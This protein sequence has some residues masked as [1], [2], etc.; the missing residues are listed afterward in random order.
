[1][2]RTYSLV[3]LL[4]SFSMI[5]S[6]LNFAPRQASA[7]NEVTDT[8]TVED[9]GATSNSYVNWTK[10]KS[11]GAEY[12][13]NSSKNGSGNNASIQLKSKDSTSGIVTTT[14]GRYAEKFEINWGSNNT[15][16]KAVLIYGRNEPYTGVSDLYGS[17]KGN[18]IGSFT[19][20]ESGADTVINADESKQYRYIG[21]RSENGAVYIKS[22][23]ITW[24]SKAP[25][26]TWADDFSS[27]SAYFEDDDETVNATITS[28]VTKEATYTADGE[29]EYTATVTY[30][31][32]TYKDIKT[33]V[34][35]ALIPPMDVTYIDADGT[36]QTHE[37]TVLTGSEGDIASGWYVAKENIT[38]S[39]LDS[40][41]SI[42]LIICDGVTVTLTGGIDARNR[43]TVYGQSDGSGTIHSTG[44]LI[45]RAKNITINGGTFIGTK[46]SNDCSLIVATD[47]SLGGNL[48]VNRGTFTDCKLR[49]NGSV[50]INGGTINA[51]R[52]D[53]ENAID[54]PHG[55]IIINGGKI[56][57]DDA[58]GTLYSVIIN[59]SDPEDSLYSKSY[60]TGSGKVTLNH[61]LIDSDGNKYPAGEYA[62]EDL[63][64][65]TLTPYIPSEWE[66][67]QDLIDN[68][69]F[70]DTITLTKDYTAGADDTALVIP[71]GK[72]I[73][74]DLGNHTLDRGL[75]DSAAEDNGNVITVYGRL[76]INGSGTVTGGKN[77][78]SG[79]AICINSGHV[80]I[81]GGV[82]TGNT[83]KEAGA[84]FN[85]EHGSLNIAGGTFTCNSAVQFGGGAIVN[86]GTMR[87]GK[88]EIKGNSALG[89]GGGIWNGGT[90]ILSGGTITGNTVMASGSNGAGI[91]NRAGS[92]I[93]AF[94]T[95]VVTGNTAFNNKANNVYIDSGNYINITGNLAS[96][97]RIA[98]TAA[99]ISMNKRVL[100]SG[101]SGSGTAD[102]FISDRDDY[103]VSLNDQGEATYTSYYFVSFYPNGG[104]GSMARIKTKESSI[105]LPDCD[106]T[107][108][109]GKAFSCWIDESNYSEHNAGDTFEL[110]NYYK[111]LHPSWETLYNITIADVENGTVTPDK[112]S[113]IKDE[114]V[115]LTVT[116]AED[117]VLDSLTVTNDSTKNEIT[118]TNGSFMMPASNVTVTA[119]FRYVR[120]TQDLPFEIHNKAD[121][122]A[123]AQKVNSGDDTA[124]YYKLAD[125]FDNSENITTTVGT[126]AHPFAGHFDGNGKTLIVKINDTDA[127]GTAPF[128]YISG[129]VI[130]DLTVEGTVQGTTHAAGLVG[131]NWSGE[132]VISNVTVDVDVTNP[133]ESGNR[134]IGGVVGH[135]KSSKITMTNVVCDSTLKNSG[136][137]AG[138][139]VGWSDDSKIVL[140][141][142]VF[143]GYYSGDGKFHPIGF[144]AEGCNVTCSVNKVFSLSGTKEGPSGIQGNYIGADAVLVYRSLTTFVS[145]KIT[146]ADGQTYYAPA[147]VEGIEEIYNA[148]GSE[149]VPGITVVNYKNETLVN[150]TDYEVSISPYPV[151]EAG[152]YTVTVTGLGIQD[153]TYTTTFEV[154]GPVP[155]VDA[156][157]ADM[158]PLTEYEVISSNSTYLSDD[159]WYVVMGDVTV[160]S[161]ITVNGD[162]NI[163][164]CDGASLHASKGITVLKD[165]SLTVWQQ[166]E[167]T[168]SILIDDVDRFCAGIGSTGVGGWGTTYCGTITV[169]GGKIT[170]AGGE[171]GAGIGGGESSHGGVI[172]INAGEVTAVG[173]MNAAGIGGGDAGNSGNITI[174]GGTVNAKGGVASAGIGAGF[175]G[176]GEFIT[177]NGG[178][179]TAKS[180]ST[181]A[182]IGG[183]EKYG[184]HNTG[185]GGTITIAGGIVTA[186]TGTTNQRGSGIGNGNGGTDSVIILSWTDETKD[187][188]SVTSD[189]YSGTVTMEMPF[190]DNDGTI[191]ASGEQNVEALAGKTVTPY[192][193]SGHLAGFTVSLEGDIGVNFHMILSQDVVNSDNAYV[194]FKVAGGASTKVFVKD[195]RDN[196]RKIGT[197]TYYVFKCNVK[198]KEMNKTVTAQLYVDNAKRGDEYTFSVRSYSKY[199]IDN[200]SASEEFAN[201]VPLV[202][203]ML[204]YGTAAQVYFDADVDDPANNVLDPEDR[205]YG[206][207]TKD[208]VSS[209]KTVIAGAAPEGVEFYGLSLILRT[210]TSLRFYFKDAVTGFT[211]KDPSGAEITDYKTGTA[212]NKFYI[213]IQD[214][215]ANDLDVTYTVTVGE[216]SITAGPLAYVYSVLDKFASDTDK[217]SLCDAVKALYT[218]YSEADDY[219]S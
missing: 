61:A 11:S 210:K 8:L 113:A 69:G 197:N 139:F 40:G 68:A 17:A 12:A 75:T 200:Q 191:Y 48:V 51:V 187:S 198:A 57:S 2:K 5:I 126:Q 193:E 98:V 158:T 102:N 53:Y 28:R 60:T 151:I 154:H 20:N 171:D 90:L 164:L 34:I 78:G 65:K 190:A 64:E 106:F 143:T 43:I 49:G 71:D 97:A 176:N 74:L 30:N 25:E 41:G 155:Y 134:H 174:N 166:T 101:L 55:D 112:V 205:T 181:G 121:W 179:V 93:N 186:S 36:P 133:A 207:V 111:S 118:V 47:S 185:H 216:L 127:Q 54:C 150:G 214:I 4:L 192:F 84:I 13:G 56:S 52:N 144:K 70:G 100:T 31:D 72:R 173:G 199:L 212:N 124:A 6:V 137:F 96:K 162:V 142:C 168:G 29:I 156:S 26:W 188:M 21:I 177:I 196:T 22:I 161:R 147:E 170:A 182:G 138:G 32:R 120:G 92:T 45:L 157:G 135:N 80:D 204:N 85:G 79:G 217:I 159:N 215:Y 167:G 175:N 108:P 105:I 128:R 27:A 66:E 76:A 123:F 213:E 163:V 122:D 146:A 46:R 194:L 149:I 33:N 23:S 201:A 114:T 77:T 14:S 208:M 3:S 130:H 125:D 218:Y 152:T 62:C 58:I 109:S 95:P 132:S 178:I 10:S 24:G 67:L 153:G 37:A 148:T 172:T 110:N 1:M 145:T 83:G 44:T 39:S 136:D 219:I 63:A 35:P 140:D 18:L 189:S 116:P 99:G 184:S 81:N 94:G 202:K 203:A 160:S 38:L 107:A 87:M 141:N 50:T 115:T 73:T 59:M 119:T 183:G 7:S 89:N 131:F 129:A 165:D 42:D 82:F 180:I 88:G 16:G 86:Y 91:Y 103:W 195:I 209:Y 9:T 211:V 206:N 15:N 104:S 19:Y 169:N 117:Y